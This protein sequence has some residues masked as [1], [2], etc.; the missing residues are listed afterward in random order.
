MKQILPIL[1]LIVYVTA[2]AQQKAMSNSE[3]DSLYYLQHK[4]PHLEAGARFMS[5]EVYNGRQ[6]DSFAQWGLHPQVSWVMKKGG[7]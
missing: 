4:Q 5:N 1:L 6:I 7:V 3:K 2:V